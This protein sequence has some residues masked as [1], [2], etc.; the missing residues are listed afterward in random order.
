MCTKIFSRK[1]FENFEFFF[2]NFFLSFCERKKKIKKKTI[3]FLIGTQKMERDPSMPQIK[4]TTSKGGLLYE[5]CQTDVDSPSNVCIEKANSNPIILIPSQTIDEC[6]A[7]IKDAELDNIGCCPSSKQNEKRKYYFDMEEWINEMTELDQINTDNVVEADKNEASP[8]IQIATYVS[9]WLNFLLL[10]AKSAALHSSQSYTII[11]SLCD[12]CLD[13]IAGVIISY[14]A[15]N[16][17]FSKEDLERFPIGKNR[18]SV[19]GILVFSILM[20]CCALYIIIQCITSLAAHERAP[21]T[22]HVAMHAMIHTIQIKFIMAIVYRC[23][24]HPITDT[25]AEDHRNDVLTNSF[26][27]FM[28]WGG[29]HFAWWMDSVG[30]ILLSLFVLYNWCQT[31]VENAKKLIGESGSNELR[32]S[33]I[34]VAACHDPIIISVEKVLVFQVGPQYFTEVHIIVPSET[35]T[36]ISHDIGEALQMKLERLPDIERAFVHLDTEKSLRMEHLLDLRIEQNN[37][38]DEE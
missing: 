16:S 22:T 17:K 28:Y 30:G 9:F 14:T 36:W 34:Y 24:H 7:A 8:C 2:E 27:L 35:P 33:I 25:L 4:Q 37:D 5:K 29:A 32:R 6:L 31:A 10:L 12:S 15:A 18:I 1:E 23:L 11:S 3:N 26:G 38:E 21:P 13:L 20:G 19:V